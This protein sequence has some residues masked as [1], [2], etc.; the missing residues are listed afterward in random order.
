M[1]IESGSQV[2][3]GHAHLARITVTGTRDV[4]QTFHRGVIADARRYS[5]HSNCRGPLGCS[6]WLDRSHTWLNSACRTVEWRLCLHVKSIT[7]KDK[8][9][10]EHGELS[11]GINWQP[12]GSPVHTQGG[13]EGKGEKYV[14]VQNSNCC[15][16]LF[17]KVFKYITCSC[18][19]TLPFLQCFS[20]KN[21]SPGNGNVCLGWEKP[22]P[23]FSWV[24][25]PSILQLQNALVLAAVKII[26]WSWQLDWWWLTSATAFREHAS[27]VENRDD[28]FSWIL[29]LWLILKAYLLQF[30]VVD[31]TYL[32]LSSRW[33]LQKHALY[34][35]IQAADTRV[36][37]EVN[38]PWTHRK[39]CGQL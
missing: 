15:I 38:F 19:Y 16:Q 17:S 31:L 29:F 34:H 30:Q 37:L 5:L 26:F 28:M 22:I 39:I 36:F 18:E 13:Q 6:L 9:G 2:C 14:E 7:Q 25:I 33:I 32:L 4:Q 35:H 10:K 24:V 8:C 1:D 20:S 11:L 3:H 21:S 23:G 27:Q 12:T